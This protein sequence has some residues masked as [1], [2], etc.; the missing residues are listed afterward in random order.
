MFTLDEYKKQQGEKKKHQFEVRKPN[1][2]HEDATWKTMKK[3]EKA[4]LE[5]SADEEEEEVV[6]VCGFIIVFLLMLIMVI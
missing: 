5:D 3:L 1:E 6:Q 2:G 4:K